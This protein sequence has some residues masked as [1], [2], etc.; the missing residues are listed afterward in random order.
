MVGRY[1]EV[2]VDAV[3]DL[4]EGEGPGR[5]GGLLRVVGAAGDGAGGRGEAEGLEGLSTLELD[6]EE[7][8]ELSHGPLHTGVE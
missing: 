7:A 4:H 8:V 3:G 5:G 2:L 1:V 6:L